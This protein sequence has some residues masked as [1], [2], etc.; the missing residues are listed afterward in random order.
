MRSKYEMTYP[1]RK[2]KNFKTKTREPLN[3][4]NI[5]KGAILTATLLTIGGT[6]FFTVESFANKDTEMAKIE[7]INKAK[8]AKNYNSENY[9]YYSLDAERIKTEDSVV[10]YIPFFTSYR[11]EGTEIFLEGKN[12]NKI[13]GV[14][15]YEIT[16]RLPFHAI[17]IRDA[18][19]VNKNPISYIEID[20]S[21][22]TKNVVVTTMA[23]KENLTDEEAKGLSQ[24]IEYKIAKNDVIEDSVLYKHIVEYFK[25]FPIIGQ[26]D[27]IKIQKPESI[28]E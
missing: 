3:F 10:D 20:Y 19:D 12:K 13:H 21:K 28:G 24:D 1:V 14:I 15:D 9:S 22:I 2:V 7:T 27:A 6:T 5:K 17:N 4:T 18:E 8:A 11:V 23:L 16:Y 25:E 26:T